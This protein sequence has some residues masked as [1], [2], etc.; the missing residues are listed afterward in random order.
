MIIGL[1]VLEGV[2]LVIE[3]LHVTSHLASI[4]FYYFSMA[5]NRRLSRS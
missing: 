2:R 5:S 4:S 3:R 1:R